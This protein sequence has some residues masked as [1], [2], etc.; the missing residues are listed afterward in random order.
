M[1]LA[2]VLTIMPENFPSRKRL[3][4]IY[5]KMMNSLVPLQDKK[6]GHWF[7]LPM[8]IQDSEK[9]NFIESSCTSMFGYAMAKGIKS[10]ILPEKT[11]IN[12]VKNAYDGISKNSIKVIGNYKTLSNVCAGTC[13]GDKFYYYKRNVGVGTEFGL[14][15]AI[16]F[17][18]AYNQL[19]KY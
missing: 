8:Q 5:Q 19:I 14:G 13:I 3:L 11:F 1:T 16:M 17:S 2:D 7:Q 10:G 12:V 18:D 9:G 4:A 6:T 15:A